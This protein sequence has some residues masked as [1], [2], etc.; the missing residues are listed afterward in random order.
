MKKLAVCGVL[1]VLGHYLS[2]SRKDDHSKLGFIGGKVDDGESI[3]DALIREVLEETGLHVE[4][5]KQYDPFVEE[6][7][8]DYLVYCYMIKLKDV[9]HES[10][11]ES[12]N[13]LIKLVSKDVL[14]NDSPWSQYNKGAFE[15][16]GSSLGL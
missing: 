2:V 10:I 1:N 11:N 5:D 3:E 8:D 13:G 15:W 6:D 7:G 12:E 16:F 9:H 4:I 14:I